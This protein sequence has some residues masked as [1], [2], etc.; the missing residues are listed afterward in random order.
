MISEEQ[1]VPIARAFTGKTPGSP[2]D[3]ISRIMNMLARPEGDP[4]RLVSDR[5]IITMGGSASKGIPSARNAGMP[6]P[7]LSATDKAVPRIIL[8]G[9]NGLA[10][11]TVVRVTP[12]MMARLMGL[13]DSYV[14]PESIPLAKTI[15]GNGIHGKVTE[16]FLQPLVDLSPGMRPKTAPS[17]ARV[18]A[19]LDTDLLK[20]LQDMF[21]DA[22]VGDLRA[23]GN[24]VR[25]SLRNRLAEISKIKLRDVPRVRRNNSSREFTYIHSMI[26]YIF[27][28]T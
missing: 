2:N 11:A 5:P 23:A 19:Q 6:A 1:A 28:L 7:T 18:A 8:P 4:L 17:T 3:E 24:V 9:A 22:S 27:L 26:C 20:W 14:I 15:L 13:P 10:D 25:A 21:P 12:R 16:N